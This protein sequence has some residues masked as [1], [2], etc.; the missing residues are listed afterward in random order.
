MTLDRSYW[1]VKH[2]C[3]FIHVSVLQIEQSD[4][5]LLSLGKPPNELLRFK[6]CNRVNWGC[7]HFVAAIERG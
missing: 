6:L 4:N 1:Y 7:G 3:H 5:F 2:L